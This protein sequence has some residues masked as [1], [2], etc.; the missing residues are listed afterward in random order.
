VIEFPS[1]I[2]PHPEI[3]PPIPDQV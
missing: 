1:V 3:I 2:V